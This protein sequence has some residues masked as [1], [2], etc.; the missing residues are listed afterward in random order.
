MSRT[1]S[2][3]PSTANTAP[4]WGGR[5]SAACSELMAEYDHP[6]S[7]ILP[8]HHS[9]SET[10]SMISTESCCSRGPRISHLPWLAPVPRTSTMIWAYPLR[11][12]FRLI[13][14]TSITPPASIWVR[15]V[16]PSSAV[17]VASTDRAAARTAPPRTGACIVV[18]M[19]SIAARL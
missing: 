11:T 18:S 14:K 12:R 1:M 9:C 15:V 4:S 16:S 19:K 7:P 2:S 8:L 5:L 6:A 10:Q 3:Q 17:P 13:P